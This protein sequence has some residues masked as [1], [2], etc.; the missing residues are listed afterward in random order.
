[1]RRSPFIEVRFISPDSAA[2][3]QTWLAAADL[4]RDD[5]DVD[6]EEAAGLDGVDDGLHHRRPIA[7]GHGVHRV[8][9]DV[10]ALLVDHVELVGVQRGL[11]VI[12]RPDVVDAA[13][14]LDQEL[15]D[16]GRRPSDMGIGRTHIA[17][18]VA[19]HAHAAAAFAADIAGR[20]RNI[21]QR[22][23]GAVVVVAPDQALLV[24][25]HG[26]PTL[27]FLGLGDP[28]RRLLDLIDRSGR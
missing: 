22:G 19:A 25:E 10:G 6:R 16:I 1:M 15:V 8:L 24:G 2:G 21:H 20:Q 5:V 23:V 17:L 9:H 3:S 13:L 4:R 12:A 7:I 27:A 26:A 18:L 14:S 28:G 11:V